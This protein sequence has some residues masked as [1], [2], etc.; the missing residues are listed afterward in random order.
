[1]FVKRF[2]FISRIFLAIIFLLAIY[3]F[4]RSDV[5]FDK[6]IVT[7]NITPR[8]VAS[9]VDTRVTLLRG[10]VA[11]LDGQSSF[12]PDGGEIVNYRWMIT[13]SPHEKLLGKVVYDGPESQ[14]PDQ[15]YSQQDVGA[16][17]YE[18]EVTDDE[19]TKH[20]DIKNVFVQPDVKSIIEPIKKISTEVVGLATSDII[21][22]I[23]IGN[24][25]MAYPAKT[26]YPHGIVNDT[27]GGEP[28][29]V[30]FCEAC[31]TGAVKKRT[32]KNQELTFVTFGGT[33][34]EEDFL[35]KDQETSSTWHAA[36]GSAESGA[37]EGAS[38]EDI[39]F[40][41]TTW[42]E[43]LNKYPVSLVLVSG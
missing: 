1:M 32:V 18:L 34:E 4:Y 39:V 31:Q 3:L 25:A 35:I 9:I 14:A 36:F 27:V 41:L 38:L 33:L 6:S 29:V 8:A 2:M 30:V 13:E 40:T 21:L 15:S 20:R 17:V 23:E 26:V 24:E 19:G 7:E 28:V 11:H 37:M 22:G 5:K 42:G 43:W 12:D 16:W 10:G